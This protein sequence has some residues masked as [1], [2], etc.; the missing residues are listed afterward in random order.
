M[1]ESTRRAVH[2]SDDHAAV[3]PSTGLHDSAQSKQVA[4]T[5]SDSEMTGT[6]QRCLFCR[7]RSPG[8]GKEPA[9]A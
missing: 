5:L 7:Y 6:A 4:S 1:Y 3:M 2:R 8:T 9:H